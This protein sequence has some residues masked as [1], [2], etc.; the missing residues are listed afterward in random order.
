MAD[1]N[2]SNSLRVN[3]EGKILF[4]DNFLEKIDNITSQ[5]TAEAIETILNNEDFA[6][7]NTLDTRLSSLETKMDTLLN[8]QDEDNNITTK[9]SGSIVEEYTGSLTVTAGSGAQLFSPVKMEGK[10]LVVDIQETNTNSHSF[11][12]FERIES[13]A[14][15]ASN[16][17]SISSVTDEWNAQG[18]LEYIRA[19]KTG[20]R[21]I[22][23]DDVD[24]DYNYVVRELV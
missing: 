21:L 24:H 15:N 11:K 4:T 7:E 6:T 20:V 3:D 13:A 17:R 9:Q 5:Q 10:I 22:N 14:G 12:L 19:T 23:E 18:S 16:K 2:F 1:T 8:S